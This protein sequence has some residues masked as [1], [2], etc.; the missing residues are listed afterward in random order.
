MKHQPITIKDIAQELGMSISTVSRA[1]NDYHH[2]S[3][4]TK[5]KVRA[6]A[7]RLGYRH[8]ALAAALRNSKSKTIG[9]IVPR[10]SMSFQSAVITAI[11]NKLYTYGYNVIICQSN[12]SPKVEIE[13]VKLLLSSRVEGI[14]ISCSINTEDFSVFNDILQEEIPLIFY[15]RVPSNFTAHKIKGDEYFGA[16]QATSH[17]IEQGCKRIAH[18]GGLLS[19]HQYLERFEGYKGALKKYD[20]SFSES[21]IHFHEL[22]R[23]N[24]LKTCQELLGGEVKPDG[25]FASNDTTALAVLEFAR[26]NDISVPNELKVVGYSNDERVSISRPS[27][28]SVEQFPHEMGEQAVVLM[29]NL[30]Q[31]KVDPGRSYISLTTPIELIKRE[32]SEVFKP[33]IVI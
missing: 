4:E 11:Q 8:N 28:T 22:T 21:L 1:L 24:A 6:T 3:E 13:M 14:I 23:E 29:M 25:I 17:L 16:F 2:I 18:I 7:E 32:S 33:E 12:E 9:L 31:R 19:C 30:I 20:L 5:I 27:I 15:D 26:N 10:I